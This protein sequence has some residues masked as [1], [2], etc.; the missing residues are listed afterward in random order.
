MKKFFWLVG[1]VSS[2]A[3]GGEF[4]WQGGGADCRWENAENWAQRSVPG[5]A[6]SA[7]FNVA[8]G[9]AVCVSNT[10]ARTKIVKTGEGVLRLNFETLSNAA[11]ARVSVLGGT[12]EF[13][14]AS[15]PKEVT[16]KA[17]FWVDPTRDETMETFEEGGTNF[18]WKIRDV[19]GNGRFAYAS[20][21]TEAPSEGERTRWTWAGR[22]CGVPYLRNDAGVSD[23]QYLEF[24]ALVCGSEA[25]GGRGAA[26]RF[27]RLAEPVLSLGIAFGDNRDI[28]T[29]GVADQAMLSYT[30]G[31]SDWARGGEGRMCPAS[32]TV[33]YQSNMTV[34]YDGNDG[35]SNTYLE[36]NR[37][38]YAMVIRRNG[39]NHNGIFTDIAGKV[40][41]FGFAG[42]Q[43]GIYGTDRLGGVRIGE[44]LLF[45]NKL[46][47]A[48]MEL[49]QL[50]LA[51]KHRVALAP[52]AGGTLA[53]ADD[54]AGTVQA[55]SVEGVDIVVDAI[56]AGTVEKRGKGRL[57][58][59]KGAAAGQTLRVYEGCVQIQGWEHPPFFHLDATRRNTMKLR[60]LDGTNLI[61]RI[62][63]TRRQG[64]HAV[65]VHEYANG[66]REPYLTMTNLAEG[67]ERPVIDFGK[68]MT[69]GSPD[70][71]WG[72]MLRFSADA[73]IASDLRAMAMVRAEHEYYTAD[74]TQLY[75][76]MWLFGSHE[77]HE[78]EVWGAIHQWVRHHTTA[79]IV[80]FV[81]GTIPPR[82]GYYSVDG[83]AEAEVPS[84]ANCKFHTL[85][86]RYPPSVPWRY[87]WVQKVPSVRTLGI[88][89][90]GAGGGMYGELATYTNGLDEAGIKRIA[91][92]LDKKWFGRENDLNDA[93]AFGELT[94]AEGARLE[95][96]MAPLNVGTATAERIGGGGEMAVH[97]LK[98]TGGV[99]IG[100]AGKAGTLGVEGDLEIGDG[101]A[102][103]LRTVGAGAVGTLEVDGKLKLGEGIAVTADSAD[104]AAVDCGEYT[105]M[106]AK[107]I[108]GLEGVKTWSVGGT[109]LAHRVAR[110]RAG[111]DG[112]SVVM[113]FTRKGFVLL[114]R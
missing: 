5:V 3:G 8:A 9:E 44:A 21:S 76:R 79:H 66:Y 53:L 27:D 80:D 101:A 85:T 72:G 12:V 7:T 33:W 28:E 6:D 63:D 20:N 43:N 1:M 89:D 106:R 83:A 48:E 39:A 64:K 97:R 34:L 73:Q 35:N 15:L 100:D 17:A 93:Y 36:P 78:N 59:E 90:K 109:V 84:I 103:G 81:D 88:S 55:R 29:T 30:G 2:F 68:Y 45:T 52:T 47:D 67:V 16:D 96:L 113:S 108:E 91:K 24:G 23:M 112:R 71:G 58:V 92:Y 95:A 86:G 11:N 54:G 99:E 65:G 51:Q 62:D 94:A 98:V 69:K 50:Y 74:G 57:V 107:E 82:H 87:S 13:P 56:S 25:V 49:V 37:E 4:V 14:K 60:E 104:G 110:V 77:V 22:K 42:R 61:E 41:G 32:A 111:D 19:R 46:S 38:L 18:V 40:D 70:S 102:V 26:M 105:I 114:V 10:F 75:N 31:G